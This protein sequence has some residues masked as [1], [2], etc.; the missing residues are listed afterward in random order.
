MEKFNEDYER[1]LQDCYNKY[2]YTDVQWKGYI[3]RVDYEEHFFAQY[4]MSLLIKMQK[5]DLNE[6][7]DLTI[8][9]LDHDYN[10]YKNTIFNLTRGDFVEFNA[11]FISEG[12]KDYGPVLEGFGIEDLHKHIKINAHIHANSRYSTNEETIHG[13]D[14]IY[15]EIPNLVSDDEVKLTQHETKHK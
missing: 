8:K 14:V 11:T 5:E 2:R 1:V 3:I 10:S 9:F 4:R 13:G 7:G 12:G 6:D 15:K